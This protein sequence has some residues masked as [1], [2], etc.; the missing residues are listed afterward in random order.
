MNSL[1]ILP[2]CLAAGALALED[3]KGND[4]IE[5]IRN[6]KCKHFLNYTNCKFDVNISKLIAISLIKC[7]YF[8]VKQ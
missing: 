6:G 7:I 1:W 5:D 8:Q 3:V 2:L 4:T